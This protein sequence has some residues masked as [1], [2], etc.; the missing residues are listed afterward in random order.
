MLCPKCKTEMGIRDGKFGQFYYC[1]NSSS[2]DP[3]K[4]ITVASFS[5]T[6]REVTPATVPEDFNDAVTRECIALGLPMDRL[7]QLAEF[8]LGDPDD[9]MLEEDHW[10]NHY[11]Y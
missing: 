11:P 1:P 6:I 2:K 9:D 7:T 5:G 3:H 4:T 8:I 10:S